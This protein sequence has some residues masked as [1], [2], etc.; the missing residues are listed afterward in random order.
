M[1]FKTSI[2]FLYHIYTL[3]QRYNAVSLVFHSYHIDRL[4]ISVEEKMLVNCGNCSALLHLSLY[5]RL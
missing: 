4:P 3:A 2:P 5:F 1:D